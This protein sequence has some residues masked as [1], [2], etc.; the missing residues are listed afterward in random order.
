MHQDQIVAASLKLFVGA[1]MGVILDANQQARPGRRRFPAQAICQKPGKEEQNNK[2]RRLR[3]SETKHG[4]ASPFR[5]HDDNQY[6]GK[7][8]RRHA[9][10][11][12]RRAAD[13]CIS[14]EERKNGIRH[15][16]G[17][18]NPALAVACER[19]FVDSKLVEGPVNEPPATA[20]GSSWRAWSV[21]LS[22]ILPI[23]SYV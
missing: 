2:N 4:A 18:R 21:G 6:M 11:R 17:L 13:R 5:M 3:P 20:M 19:V 9:I 1:E 23:W 7:S 8:V 16:G 22:K 10:A 15:P 14:I 12:P